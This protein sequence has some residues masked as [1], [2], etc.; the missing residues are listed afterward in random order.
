[1]DLLNPLPEIKRSI[2]IFTVLNVGMGPHPLAYADD[3][4]FGAAPIGFR[5]ESH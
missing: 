2:F 3:V 1:M 5:R 4:V